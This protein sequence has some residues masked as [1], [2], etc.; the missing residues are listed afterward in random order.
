M[1][2]FLKKKWGC[3]PGTPIPPSQDLVRCW[4]FVKRTYILTE[5]LET[6]MPNFYT[7][8]GKDVVGM[9]F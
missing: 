8:G 4:P 7:T 2:F 9:G 3:I 5:N 1:D 6:V